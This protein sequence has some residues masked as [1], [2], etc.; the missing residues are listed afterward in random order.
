M[1]KSSRKIA[2]LALAV[3]AAMPAVRAVAQPTTRPAAA[4]PSTR[5]VADAALPT[6]LPS[7]RPP[8]RAGSLIPPEQSTTGPV[9]RADIANAYLRFEQ[10]FGS[11]A[12][13][14]AAPQDAARAA[15]LNEAFDA[16]NY[17]M[18]RNDLPRVAKL[19]DQI[20]DSLL[21][22]A[23]VSDEARAVRA[24][25][26][27]VE[28]QVIADG[29]KPNAA[30]PAPQLRVTRLYDVDRPAETLAFEVSRDGSREVAYSIT[31]R[32]DPAQKSA[33]VV[34]LADLKLPAG[35]YVAWLR[36]PD[37]SRSPAT[38]LF[39]LEPGQSPEAMRR[40]FEARADRVASR[41]DAKP[42]PQSLAAF[43][44]R[45]ALL[46][47]RL[48][49]NDMA[50]FL[51]D[52]IEL[53]RQLDGEIALLEQGRDPYARR[54]GDYWRAFAAGVTIVPARVYAP[55]AALALGRPLPLIIALHGAGGDENLFME[56]YGNGAIKK[57]ADEFGFIVLSPS[58][59]TVMPNP[60]AFDALID[61][62]RD[63]YD[64]DG[65][66]IYV[67]GHSMG[68][69]VAGSWAT[70][71]PDRLAAACLIAGGQVTGPAA[72]PSLVLAAEFD[73]LF[74]LPRLRDNAE[75]AQKT[76]LPVE[77]RTIA[78]Y[79]H[80]LA[81]NGSLP[82]AVKWLLAHQLTPKPPTTRPAE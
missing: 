75:A 73:T 37:G 69:M 60:Q 70:L 47:S 32:V 56:G 34:P 81:V 62:M 19:L 3:I 74:R 23:Q 22:D 14:G 30:R 18:V 59:Y 21:P 78:N 24:L 41:A 46:S 6:T 38:R 65:T 54:A 58:T 27:R 76:G 64:I 63:L 77:F 53:S 11:V 29:P 8:P 66:R 13:G 48:L 7:R 4:E 1:V 55:P 52:P 12:A 9:T 82:E 57:L 49:E 51:A 80:S 45:A 2:T 20:T 39:V 44:A 61:A 43:R 5:A 36:T 26:V 72:A 67:V 42:H 35:R 50:R 79:G 40:A 68:A 71:H 28:P 25:R 10:T 17:F 16:V 15:Q 33:A 31:I